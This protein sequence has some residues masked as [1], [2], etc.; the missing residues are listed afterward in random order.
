[1]Q[2]YMCPMLFPKPHM[3]CGMPSQGP[4]TSQGFITYHVNL[5]QLSVLAPVFF[6]LITVTITIYNVVLY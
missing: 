6:F 4:S 3:F 5:K 2:I 1:M